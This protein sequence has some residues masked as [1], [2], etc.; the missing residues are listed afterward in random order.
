MSSRQLGDHTDNY[1]V[2]GEHGA[3]PHRRRDPHLRPADRG[4]PPPASYHPKI[5]RRLPRQGKAPPQ[6]PESD[7]WGHGGGGMID[8]QRTPPQ[9]SRHQQQQ[10]GSGGSNDTD[11]R[12]QTESQS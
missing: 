6:V 10:R 1:G 2:T 4:R 8:R 5:Q 12:S 7:L 9:R 11:K 3:D